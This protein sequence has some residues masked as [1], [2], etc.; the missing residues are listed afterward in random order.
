MDPDGVLA[1]TCFSAAIGTLLCALLSN[2]PFALASGMG[3]NAYFAYTLCG[4]FSYTWQQAL[5]LTFLS[6]LLF[7]LVAVSPLRDKIIGAVPANLKYAISAGI[8]VFIALIG[9][10][11]CAAP[12]PSPPMP[13]PLRALPPAERP[14]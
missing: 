14:A 1:A 9:L 3:M 2:K 5:A 6:G 11:D 4:G 7:L 12:P 10:L 13:S 8:G